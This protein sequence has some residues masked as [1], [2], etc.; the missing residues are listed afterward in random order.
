MKIATVSF[1]LILALIGKTASL[2]CYRCSWQTYEGK[3]YGP[4]ACKSPFSA[5][6]TRVTEEICR[7]NYQCRKETSAVSGS[8]VITRVSRGCTPTCE[9][10]CMDGTFL[11]SAVKI[12]SSCC[13]SDLCNHAG[14]VTLDLVAMTVLVI[15]TI[16]TVF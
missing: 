12:C 8:D 3:E 5:N 2:K 1:F 13:S 15:A 7:Q 10:K 14:P 9:E 16:V 11:G 6:S 4:V